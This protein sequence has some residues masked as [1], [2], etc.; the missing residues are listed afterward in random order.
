MW[1]GELLWLASSSRTTR[2][3]LT[4][5]TRVRVQRLNFHDLGSSSDHQPRIEVHPSP[6]L[7]SRCP[8]APAIRRSR[9]VNFNHRTFSKV[10][11][12]HAMLLVLSPASSSLLS[13][14]YSLDAYQQGTLFFLLKLP[15]FAQLYI[16]ERVGG[17]NRSSVAV[18]AFLRHA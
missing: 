2:W 18:H 12:D 1:I 3:S 14:S 7:S 10:N 13:F 9:T 6:S 16:G 5:A 15:R 4:F 8:L 17:D 11:H